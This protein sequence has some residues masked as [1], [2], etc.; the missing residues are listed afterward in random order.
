MW[1]GNGF[2]SLVLLASGSEHS[3]LCFS[4]RLMLNNPSTDV[5]PTLNWGGG[6]CLH[7]EAVNSSSCAQEYLHASSAEH[8]VE[9]VRCYAAKTI[10]AW[11]QAAGWCRVEPNQHHWLHQTGKDIAAGGEFVLKGLNPQTWEGKKPNQFDKVKGDC[12]ILWRIQGDSHGVTYLQVTLKEVMSLRCCVT[13]Q[14]I[15]NLLWITGVCETAT[16]SVEKSRSAGL[17]CQNHFVALILL[18]FAS[19]VKSSWGWDVPFLSGCVN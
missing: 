5:T 15:C 2:G 17:I 7:I 12:H 11:V 6:G 3:S 1:H 13:F 10:P 9:R 8:R 14:R 19:N 4:H 18:R 16:S